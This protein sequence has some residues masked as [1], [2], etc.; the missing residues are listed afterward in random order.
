[1]R[2]ASAIG[3]LHPILLVRVAP[4]LA[5]YLMAGTVHAGS[6]DSLIERL[7]RLEEENRQLRR[8]LDELKA[9]QHG[10]EE[11]EPRIATP[12]IGEPTED[13]A[14]SLINVDPEHGYEIL[15]P[16][17]SINRKQLLILERKKDGTL[18]PD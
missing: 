18:A 12:A 17:T 4:I 11:T 1:M 15:D 9:E 14:A 6:V 2:V 10:R 16:T 5:L 7:D 13:S 3:W 8:E